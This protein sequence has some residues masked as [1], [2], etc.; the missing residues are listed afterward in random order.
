MILIIVVIALLLDTLLPEPHFFVKRQRAVIKAHYANG[1]AVISQIPKRIIHHKINS[2]RAVSFPL[3]L[4]VWNDDDQIRG[5]PGWEHAQ[6]PRLPYHLVVRPAHHREPDTI[7]PG[8]P[9]QGVRFHLAGR[10][11][12]AN[13]RPGLRVVV[14]AQEKGPVRR[15][16]RPQI[17]LP[18]LQKA[19]L[20][21]SSSAENFFRY[22][23]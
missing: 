11:G 19:V 12:R 1:D 21:T 17:D 18:A 20:H 9:G 23:F 2:L 13:P 6:K 3:V 15:F 8:S 5:L 7:L 4:G 14:P 10:H 16:Q 22:S